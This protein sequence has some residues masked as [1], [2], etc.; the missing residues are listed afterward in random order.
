MVETGNPD[1]LKNRNNTMY[2]G[3]IGKLSVGDSLR[4]AKFP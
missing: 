2:S 1:S 4:Q 3:K